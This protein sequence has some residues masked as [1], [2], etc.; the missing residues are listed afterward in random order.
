VLKLEV[1]MLA[2]PLA[3][4]AP[5]PRLVFPSKKVTVPDGVPAF[6]VTEAVMVIDWPKTE[7][8]GDAA[9]V[10][11]VGAGFTICVSAEML[12]A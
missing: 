3:F 5:V 8:F 6:D 4:S 12:G 2:C 7:G 10:V 1:L 11:A 9:T